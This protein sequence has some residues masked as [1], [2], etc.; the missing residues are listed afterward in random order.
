MGVYWHESLPA[1]ITGWQ[2]LLNFC[3]INWLVHHLLIRCNRD[4]SHC[5]L[6]NY[7]EYGGR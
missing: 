1:I 7:L 3:Q 4:Q 2:V 5:E 6:Y